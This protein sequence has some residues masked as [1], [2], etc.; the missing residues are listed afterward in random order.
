MVSFVQKQLYKCNKFLVEIINQIAQIGR[1][2][3]SKYT[4]F[5]ESIELRG[6]SC[7][8]LK[9]IVEFIYTGKLSIN[10]QSVQNILAVARHMQVIPSST[11][12]TI[13]LSIY[14]LTYCF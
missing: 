11:R 14:F 6:I 9:H 1:N 2:D 5:S 3:G 8:G 12:N 7:D 13:F 4:W 10:M